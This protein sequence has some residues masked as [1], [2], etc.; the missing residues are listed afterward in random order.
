MLMNR[1]AKAEANSFAV[2][3]RLLAT[4]YFGND[5]RQLLVKAHHV[6]DG[7]A[8]TRRTYQ[9][10]IESVQQNLDELTKEDAEYLYSEAVIYKEAYRAFTHESAQIYAQLHR[11]VEGAGEDSRE[12][13]QH[14]AVISDCLRE[15]QQEAANTYKTL[16][17]CLPKLEALLDNA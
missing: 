3:S 10:I 9:G 1:K 14:A 7:L 6:Y 17:T 15:R 11:L 12:I 5:G 16:Q 8:D 13:S 2:S 4:T